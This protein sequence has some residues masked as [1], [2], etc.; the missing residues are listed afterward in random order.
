MNDKLLAQQA[1]RLRVG[2]AKEEKVSVLVDNLDA[3][4]QAILF[5]QLFTMGWRWEKAHLVKLRLGLTE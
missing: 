2:K 3:E 1:E 5:I 4:D